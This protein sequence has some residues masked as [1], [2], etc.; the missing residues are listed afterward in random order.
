MGTWGRVIVAFLVGVLTTYV[1]G[2]LFY[3]QLNLSNLV[4]LGLTVD[5]GTRIQAAG[6][7][8]LGMTGL[9][10]P[11]VAVA[12]LIAFLV[13]RGIIV[14]VPQLRSIGYTLAG[15]VAILTI[16]FALNQAFGTHPLAVTRTSIGLLSQCVAGALGGFA[17]VSCLPRVSA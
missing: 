2:V 11:I 1:V 15:F 14:F 12:L 6:H 5:L 8:L 16:D 7:D 13:A 3:T 9:Y 17:F 4:E 10:L